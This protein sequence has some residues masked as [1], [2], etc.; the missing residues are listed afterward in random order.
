[1]TAR[2]DDIAAAVAT[3]DNANPK[4]RLPRSVAQLL[5]VM[6]PSE[7]VC[8]RSLDDLASEGFDRSNLPR[9][10][11]RLIEAGFLSKQTSAGRVP[12]IYTLHLPPRVHP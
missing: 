5:A 7:D 1:M 6:F 10:L 3:Y 9:T 2:R 11:R 12:T 4:G 8:R